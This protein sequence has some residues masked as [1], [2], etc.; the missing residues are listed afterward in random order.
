MNGD[1]EFD[2]YEELE[3]PRNSTPEE[4]KASYRRLARV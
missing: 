2:L 1:N 4:I 3:I